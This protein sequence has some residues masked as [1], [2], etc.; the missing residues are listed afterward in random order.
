[1]A[2]WEN[3]LKDVAVVGIGALAGSFSERFLLKFLK[4]KLY[5]LLFGL[6][7]LVAG[8]Y[9]DNKMAKEFLYGF[10]AVYVGMYLWGEENA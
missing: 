5:A 8:A 4:S 1:M 10:G 3:I 9:M 2:S 7:I 6:V